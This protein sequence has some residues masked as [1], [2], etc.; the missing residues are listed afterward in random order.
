LHGELGQGSFHCVTPEDQLERYPQWMRS[1]RQASTPIKAFIRKMMLS[2]L[3]KVGVKLS[4]R[5]LE[6]L[7]CLGRH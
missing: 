1:E 7:G 3:G 2:G 4:R 6:D 5:S